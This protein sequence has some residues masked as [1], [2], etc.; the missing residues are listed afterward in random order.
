MF[1]NLFK[2][3]DQLIKNNKTYFTII[4]GENQARLMESELTP[5]PSDS[6]GCRMGKL[7]LF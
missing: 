1:I 5:F 6:A 7:N 4:L 3:L 2:M